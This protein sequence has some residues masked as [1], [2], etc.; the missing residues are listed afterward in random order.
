MKYKR[1]RGDNCGIRLDIDCKHLSNKC[2]SC[3]SSV[4]AKCE[5]FCPILVLSRYN[6][7][8]GME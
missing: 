6:E 2:H 3:S 8:N 5:K 1:F 7:W 4:R